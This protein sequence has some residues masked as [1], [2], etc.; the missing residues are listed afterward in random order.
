MK[1]TNGFTLIELL[2]V[3]GVLGILMGML[4][5]AVGMVREKALQM[6][7]GQ[8]MRQIGVAVAT[9]QHATGRAL[10]GDTMGAWLANLAQ[11][12]GVREGKL[13]LFDED[14]AMAAI[15]EAVPPALVELDAGG[16]WAPINNF[17]NWPIGVAVV[18]GV[19]PL[20]PPATTPVAWTRG[21]Q[22]NGKWSALDQ[23]NPGVYG[24]KGGFIVF[25]DGHVEFHKDLAADGGQLIHYT[26]GRR[27]ADIRQ[28]INPGAKVIDYLGNVF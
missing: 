28:A 22:A 15:T 21:L 2:M 26:T 16:R 19:H 8:K 9:Y 20:A 25:L 13:F 1:K 12:T 14:P 4:V 5:P 11:H 18:S 24:D 7:T 17:A 3:L 10:T 6:A 27:T 23:T